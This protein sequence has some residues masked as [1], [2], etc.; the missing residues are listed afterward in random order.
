MKKLSV[1]II[2][3]AIL[4]SCTQNETVSVPKTNFI[5]FS[6]AFVDKATRADLSINKKDDLKEFSVW[7]HHSNVVILK[8]ITVTKQLDE[9]WDYSISPAKPQWEEGEEYYFH[10][11][12]PRGAMNITYP[13]FT[14]KTGIPSNIYYQ[15]DV[16]KRKQDLI[17]ANHNRVQGLTI[18]GEIVDYSKVDFTF[19]HLLSRVMFT[20]TNKLTSGESIEILDVQITNV[21]KDAIVHLDDLDHTKWTWDGHNAEAIYNFGGTGVIPAVAGANVKPAEDVLFVIPA[22]ARD[23]EVLFTIKYGSETS[24]KKATVSGLQFEMGYSY[25]FKAEI[26]DDD[27]TKPNNEINFDV[28]DVQGWDTKVGSDVVLDFN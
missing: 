28:V 27:V 24:T 25:N 21:Q 3:L 19:H 18:L 14:S 11:F 8:N 23:Y 15:L 7:G 6:D 9:T 16:D 12:A 2:V 5:S 22:P 17:Y 20:F 10:A 1:F 26:N 13:D 4:A